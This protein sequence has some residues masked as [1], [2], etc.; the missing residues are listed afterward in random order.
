[1]SIK[2]VEVTNKKLLKEFINFQIE[3]YKGNDQFIP[4]MIFDE[5]NFFDRKKNPSY[6][7]CDTVLYL[8]YKDDKV[9]GR[10]CGLYNPV[11]N[12]KVD[13]SHLRFT[14]YDVIDDIEVSKALFAAI[15]KWG[16]EKY[17]LK[18]FDGPIGF[19]DF[20]KQ[21]MLT[22]GYELEGMSIT[23]Y[24]YP[25]YVEHMEKL[26][27]VKDVDWVE[28]KVYMPKEVDPRLERISSMLM[29]R[30]GYKLLRFKNKKEIEARLDDIFAAYNAAFEPLHGVVP[31]TRSHIE[32][33][34][35]QYIKLIDKKYIKVVVDEHDKVVAFGLLI[36]SL[37]K[38]M[39]KNKG[40][41]FPFGWI[42]LLNALKNPKVLDMYFIAV[43][44]EY[45]GLGIN[46]II[47]LDVLKDAIKD[48]IEYAET[49]PEL[50]DNLKVQAQWKGYD[51]RLVRR[52]RCWMKEIEE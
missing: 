28:F 38:A 41:M 36:P 40:K 48:G 39:K 35:D 1:M 6:E 34:Y 33:Y 31:L 42:P 51:T 24:N 17:G 3:L 30:R 47:M 25:Y 7:Y 9:V 18:T 45:Q 8:A 11:Y 13:V 5:L 29:D 52:R 43:L 49:G 50:D 44:P 27:F 19:T 26:G 37:S 4:P 12:K 21:G 46:S 20:D 32:A 2:I 15:G 14:H 10:I 23:N 22:E 16:K